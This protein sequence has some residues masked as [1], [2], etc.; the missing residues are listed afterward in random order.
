M[1]HINNLIYIENAQPKP[2]DSLRTLPN[3]RARMERHPPRETSGNGDGMTK[4]MAIGRSPSNVL[5]DE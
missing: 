4:P 2:D 1:R 5:L 3:G